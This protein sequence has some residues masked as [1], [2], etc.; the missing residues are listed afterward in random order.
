MEL[1][2]KHRQVLLNE[3][4]KAKKD[5]K[6]NQ[7]CLADVHREDF[8]NIFEI[9]VFLATERINLI[10]TTLINNEINF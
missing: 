4:E 1:E 9:A 8:K 6:L 5:L 10:E 7:E 3:L 2:K